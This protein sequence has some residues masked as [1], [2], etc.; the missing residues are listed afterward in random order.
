V[1]RHALTDEEKTHVAALMVRQQPGYSSLLEAEYRRNHPA[2]RRFL[3]LCFPLSGTVAWQA[4]KARLDQK[5]Q[6]Y[7]LSGQEERILRQLQSECAHTYGDWEVTEIA[8]EVAYL[9]RT[10]QH[11][12]NYEVKE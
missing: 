2:P 12:Q 5:L 4:W 11:C 10:C 7:R 9:V 3:F 1:S 6:P 8:G